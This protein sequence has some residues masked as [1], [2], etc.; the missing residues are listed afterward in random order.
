MVAGERSAALT[1]GE[2]FLSKAEGVFNDAFQGQDH[3]QVHRRRDLQYVPE[4]AKFEGELPVI[5]GSRSSSVGRRR[6]WT[7][8]AR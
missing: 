8:C 1:K 6:T 3:G 2:A 7:T 4:L 5:T